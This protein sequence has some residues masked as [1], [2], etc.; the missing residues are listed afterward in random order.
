MKNKGNVYIEVITALG[1]LAAPALFWTATEN[2][3]CKDPDMCSGTWKDDTKE[4][5]CPP[6]CPDQ[7]SCQAKAAFIGGSLHYYCRCG[8]NEPVCSIRVKV[9]ENGNYVS[10]TCENPNC[11]GGLTC[12]GPES[13]PEPPPRTYCIC[14]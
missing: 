3:P 5:V 12:E 2:A 8:T 9:D 4:L 6:P 13:N 11:A 14:R 7:S 1:L 10:A